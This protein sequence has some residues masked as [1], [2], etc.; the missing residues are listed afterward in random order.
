MEVVYV[1]LFVK[2]DAYYGGCCFICYVKL[3]GGI[4]S[5]RVFQ[6]FF[7]IFPLSLVDDVSFMNQLCSDFG[8]CS[9]GITCGLLD[10][11]Q[12]GDRLGMKG[13]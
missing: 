6:E 3:P 11:R 9:S 1:C 12:L 13:I 2:N 8:H 4:T 7:E 10:P 5:Q